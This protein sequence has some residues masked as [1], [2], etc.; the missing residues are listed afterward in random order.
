MSGPQAVAVTPT[1]ATVLENIENTKYTCIAGI[2]SGPQ[3]V[4]V[5]FIKATVLENI[6]NTKYTCTL[7]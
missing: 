1:K 6:E 5:T 7:E 2:K 4:A 3:A